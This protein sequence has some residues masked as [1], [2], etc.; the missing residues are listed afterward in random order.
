MLQINKL[1]SIAKDTIFAKSLKESAKKMFGCTF[2]CNDTLKDVCETINEFLYECK[3][4]GRIVENEF[5]TSLLLSLK[6]HSDETVRKVVAQL[7]PESFLKKFFDDRSDVV[8]YYVAQ[9]LGKSD[10]LEL[11]RRYPNDFML[12]TVIVENKKSINIEPFELIEK[13]K[14]DPDYNS[15]K[16]KQEKVVKQINDIE[17]SDTWY[18]TQAKNILM[19]YGEFSYG[20]PRHVERHWN[21]LAVK[22]YC[23]SIKATSGV[24]I[25]RI[26]LQNAVNKALL[27]YDDELLSSTNSLQKI[28][29]S[30]QQNI[31]VDVANQIPTL[32]I[33]EGLNKVESLLVER[34]EKKFYN[35]F[36]DMFDVIKKKYKPN[37]HQLS[38]CIELFDLTVP[39]YCSIPEGFVDEVT[40]KA[41][42]RYTSTWNSLNE[43]KKIQLTWNVSNNDKCI[44]VFTVRGM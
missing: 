23:D 21:P 24:V 42:N 16:A 20:T 22:R 9:R 10:L 26:K 39:K 28:K 33:D 40:C 7:L 29:E 13:D 35:K 25:D 19:Q 17:L 36:E 1:R 31:N 8:R 14:V 18:E 2:Q 37:I 15:G 5:K 11:K 41:L 44:V 3:T 32:L 30:L 4:E 34:D 43:S 38:E 27:Q 12:Q 6:D